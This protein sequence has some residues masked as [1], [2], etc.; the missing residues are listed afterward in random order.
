M[1]NPKAFTLTEALVLLAI[2]CTLVGLLVPSV[3]RVFDHAARA[4]AVVTREPAVSWSLYTVQHDGHWFVLGN[5]VGF[6]HPD[7]PC[8]KRQAEAD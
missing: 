4:T 8:R 6:H 2:V 5:R 7:C 3:A 1:R